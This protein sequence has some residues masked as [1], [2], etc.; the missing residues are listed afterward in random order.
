MSTSSLTPAAAIVGSIGLTATAGSFCLFCE[1]GEGGLPAV[2]FASL[3][4][5]VAAA[6]AT[7]MSRTTARS[8]AVRISR[9]ISPLPLESIDDPKPRGSAG[10][11]YTWR[12]AVAAPTVVRLERGYVR[13]DGSDAGEFLERML[14]NEVVSL[15]PGESRPA[16]LL[17]PKSKIIAPLRVVRE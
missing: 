6:S 11:T 14:S 10:A 1:N 2:T 4:G 17:T 7:G 3:P 8:T 15:A 9:F 16:L 12:M 5:G 13:V